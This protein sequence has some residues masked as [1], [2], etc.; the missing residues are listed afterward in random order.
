[1]ID[2]YFGC[3]I[4]ATHNKRD[5]YAECWNLLSN[6]PGEYQEI[7]K[8]ISGGLESYITFWNAYKISYNLYYCP[9]GNDRFVDAE[10]YL[11]K[12]GDLSKPHS[13]DQLI[14]EFSFA[15]EGSGWRIKGGKELNNKVSSYCEDQ[16]R[17]IRPVPSP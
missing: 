12:W 11:Y 14:L 7:L 8:N 13:R 4:D 5:D 15:L 16:P 6:K 10:Y 1:M 2:N 9:R 17:V 3:I